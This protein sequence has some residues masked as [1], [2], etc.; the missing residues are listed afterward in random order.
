V[1]S[2]NFGT[3]VQIENLVQIGPSLGC[4][5]GYEMH[6]LKMGLHFSFGDMN[7]KF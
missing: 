4:L 2:R 5:K 7:L 1:I 3:K 6:I